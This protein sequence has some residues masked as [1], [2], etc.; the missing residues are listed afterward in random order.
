MGVSFLLGV[1]A[2]ILI[3]YLQYCKHLGAIV[4]GIKPNHCLYASN[5]TVEEIIAILKE[6]V[7]VKHGYMA[8]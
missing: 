7:E 5:N 6:C 1:D 4:G 2:T 3:K 8:N